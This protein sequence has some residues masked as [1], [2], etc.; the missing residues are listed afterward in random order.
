MES[1][2][3]KSPKLP[4]SPK[5]PILPMQLRADQVATLFNIPDR[6]AR[7]W[8][9]RARKHFGKPPRSIISPNEFCDWRGISIEELTRN[10]LLYF[11]K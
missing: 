10:Y 6:T 1:Y 9:I 11:G 7:D 2:P 3:P 5:S 4:F 8:L